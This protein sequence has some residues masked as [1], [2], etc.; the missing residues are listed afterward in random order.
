MKRIDLHLHSYFSDGTFSPEE[1][2]SRAKALGISGISITDHDRIEAAYEGKKLSEKYGIEYVPGTELTTMYKGGE[3][4]ILGYFY[5]PY[6]DGLKEFFDEID[7]VRAAGIRSMLHKLSKV[8]FHLTFEDVL[9]QSVSDYIGRPHIAKAL[10]AKGYLSSV[11]EAF[12]DEYIGNE[13]KCYS[14]ISSL[15]PRD[16]IEKILEFDGIPVIAHPGS[17]KPGRDITEDE[18]REFREFGLMGIE[19]LQSRHTVEQTRRF[20]DIATR[21][22]L[23]MTGGSDCHGNYYPKVLMGTVDVPYEYLEKLRLKKLEMLEKGFG[24]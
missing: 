20:I 16:A 14:P 19:V 9:A 7:R 2:F 12:T 17:F 3:V 5:D 11:Q 1:I 13:G 15:S 6:A 8:G 22:G 24:L 18:I 23:L 10:V 4:H 21:L